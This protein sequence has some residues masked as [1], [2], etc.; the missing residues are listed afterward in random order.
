MFDFG[1]EWYHILIFG[2]LG[3]IGLYLL[4]GIITIVFPAPHFYPV[5]IYHPINPFS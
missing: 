4:W 2:I 5:H 3:G 1:I